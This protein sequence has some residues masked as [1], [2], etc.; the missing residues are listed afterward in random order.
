MFVMQ[1]S[2]AK[3][4]LFAVPATFLGAFEEMAS[5]AQGSTQRPHREDVPLSF[6]RVDIPLL[7]VEV[8]V[9]FLMPLVK[10]Q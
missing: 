7:F 10:A 5:R 3:S 2:E 4:P 1:K 6:R 8:S 9:S